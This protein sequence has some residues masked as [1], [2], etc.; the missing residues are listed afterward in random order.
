MEE[1]KM[2]KNIILFIIVTFLTASSQTYPSRATVISNMDYY[3]DYEFEI[4]DN[5]TNHWQNNYYNL[6]DLYNISTFLGHEGPWLKAPYG[7]GVKDTPNELYTKRWGDGYYYY[8]DY[9]V[10]ETIYLNNNLFINV[11]PY[12]SVDSDELIFTST[13]YLPSGQQ[14]ITLDVDVDFESVDWNIE[15]YN[16][17]YD[18][19]NN[20]SIYT[21]NFVWWSGFQTG[22][23]ILN[24]GNISPTGKY[25]IRFFNDDPL[26]SL[27]VD[28]QITKPQVVPDPPDGYAAG[29]H[30]KHYNNGV[31]QGVYTD[32]W[33]FGID[34]SGFV[35][36]GYFELNQSHNTTWY[37]DN[38]YPITEAQLAEADVIVKPATHI[39]M[40]RDRFGDFVNVY[41][42][43]GHLENGQMPDGVTITNGVLIDDFLLDNY[44]LRSPY[45]PTSINSKQEIV[46][47]FHL[48]QNFPNP[49]N[50]KTT[51][52]FQLPKSQEVNLTIFNTLGQKIRVLFSGYKEAGSY[53]YQWNG[54]D[55]NGSPVSSGIYFYQL[56]TNNF[57]DTRKMLLIE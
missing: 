8:L 6:N 33:V 42:S 38:L 19:D 46:T 27:N 23:Q 20:Q 50:P 48:F 12:Q 31:A 17:G 26:L 32:S 16:V 41:E 30:L 13:N 39:Y 22:D 2:F 4:N 40:V 37:H 14:Y 9:T 11:D 57:I 49:F 56:K 36:Y 15:I 55:D 52:E 1:I 24:T 53:R 21:Y 28:I 18:W 10:T 5:H 25:I 47:D 45:S 3:H 7:Y 51:I 43:A 44:V 34:C 54:I 29:A 35:S